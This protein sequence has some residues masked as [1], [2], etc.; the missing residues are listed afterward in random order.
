MDQKQNKRS[1]SFKTFI[2]KFLV[3]ISIF[4]LFHLL[5]AFIL[6]KIPHYNSYFAITSWGVLVAS[7]LVFAA[8]QNKSSSLMI[9][10]I[11]WAAFCLLM[12]LTGFIVSKGEVDF[13]TFFLKCC[14]L[15]VLTLLFFIAF[16]FFARKKHKRNKFHFSK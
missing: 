5:A 3:C 13:F 15:F 2:V 7:S 6:L 11:P 4:V 9:A 12:F 10:S 16:R 1:L 8:L 14:L